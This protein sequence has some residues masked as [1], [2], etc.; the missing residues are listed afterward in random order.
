MTTKEEI[1]EIIKNRYDNYN[2]RYGNDIKR[3]HEYIRKLTISDEEFLSFLKDCEHQ[4]PRPFYIPP[5]GLSKLIN[6]LTTSFS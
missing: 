3:T 1:Q 6:K 5:K 4:N 2:S